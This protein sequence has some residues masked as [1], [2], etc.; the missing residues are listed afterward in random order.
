MEH[1]EVKIDM[2]QEMKEMSPRELKLMREMVE[3][4]KEMRGE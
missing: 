3:K 4:I 1:E 2:R